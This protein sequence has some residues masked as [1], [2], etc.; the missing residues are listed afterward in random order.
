MRS[1]HLY[2]FQPGRQP[3]HLTQTER[4]QALWWQASRRFFALAFI[5][6]HPSA[7]QSNI[8]MS[9]RPTW[10]LSVRGATCWDHYQWPNGAF[11]PPCH[12]H[13][14]GVIPNGH[15]SDKWLSIDL[16]YPPRY[17][18]NDGILPE[19]C[20]LTYTSVEWVAEV[21]ASY[22]SR[23]LLVKIVAYCLVPVHPLHRPLLAVE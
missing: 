11:L 5:A 8:Q 23:G 15:R 16:S 22:P 2:R 19:F 3:W 9:F 21:V 6:H 10:T 18:V 7:E 14:F 4:L 13:R 20:S 12:I 17:S 1:T